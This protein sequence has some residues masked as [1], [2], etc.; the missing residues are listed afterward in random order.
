MPNTDLGPRADRLTGEVFAGMVAVHGPALFGYLRH[1]VGQRELA[2]DLLQ[3]TFVSAFVHRAQFHPGSAVKA[4]LF[5]IAANRAR[6]ALRDGRWTIA[7]TESVSARLG[8]PGASPPTPEQEALRHELGTRL[9]EALASLPHDRREAI[10]LRDVEGLTYAEMARI[11]GGTEGA[12][13]V[14]VHR[15][16]EQLRAQLRPYLAADRESEP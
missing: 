16:R 9:S 12:A 11:A 15:G 14:R 6:N 5:T 10:I 8:S 1:M 13:R 3:D 2:E 7:D 4:W